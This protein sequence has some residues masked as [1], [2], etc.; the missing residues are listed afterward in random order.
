MSQQSS[1]NPALRFGALFGVGWGVLLSIN[2][3]FV[4]V[5]GL[6]FTTIAAIVVSLA[7]YL[8]AG[9]LAAAQTGNVSTGL[10]AG[11]WTGLFSSLLN[12]VGVI[13]ILLTNHDLIVKARQ[14][15]QSTAA[16]AA[17]GGQVAHV[18]DRLIVLLSIFGLVVGMV[19]ATGIG[20]GMG[21]LGGLIGKSRAPVPQAYQ[22]AM[23]PG[24][25]PVSPWHV[26]GASS[27]LPPGQG[28]WQQPPPPPTGSPR[29]PEQDVPGQGPPANPPQHG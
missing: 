5:Q 29:L 20:V 21:A 24:S 12:T 17:A 19:L 14:A 2:Y 25:P 26:P 28:G 16:R 15:A 23:Y 3:Y 22:E 10:V 18:T 11:L 27:P 4:H 9:I 7:V 8:V 6:R 13:V 1:G